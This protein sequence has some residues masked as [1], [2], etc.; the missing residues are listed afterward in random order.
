MKIQSEIKQVI[1]CSA[2]SIPTNAVSKIYKDVTPLDYNS[3]EAFK[4]YMIRLDKKPVTF[5][6]NINRPQLKE[7]AKILHNTAKEEIGPITKQMQ[8]FLKDAPGTLISRPKSEK[9]IYQNLIGRLKKDEDLT[10]DSLEQAK[11][12]IPDLNGLR[13]VLNKGNQ[14]D[15]NKTMELITKA[16]YEDKELSIEKVMNHGSNLKLIYMPDNSL[17]LFEFKNIPCLFASQGRSLEKTT[18]FGTHFKLTNKEGKIF[19]LQ[20]RGP[21]VDKLAETEHFLYQH[22]VK[23]NKLYSAKNKK[24][25][26]VLTTHENL[27]EEDK[28]FYLKYWQQLFIQAR[29]KELGLAYEEVAFPKNLPDIL[30]KENIEKLNNK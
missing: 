5:C 28:Y 1:N 2:K 30:R 7:F 25:A 27:G 11:E 23:G 8:E 20:I 24:L 21:E 13:F 14:E 19:E 26:E 4:Q 22:S 3:A 29:N 16:W 10:I 9:S 12:L 6:G 17:R 18:I 15:M